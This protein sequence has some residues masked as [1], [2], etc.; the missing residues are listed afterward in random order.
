MLFVGGVPLSHLTFTL[1]PLL[2]LAYFFMM[3]AGYRVRR[4]MSFLNPWEYSSNEG[5]QIIH[6]LLAFGTGGIWGVGIGKGYQKLFYLPEPHT[7]FIF[8]IIGEELGLVGVLAILALYGMVVGRGLSISRKI[9]E[10]FGSYLA[11]GM[12]IAI[13]IQVFI[14]MGVTLGLLPTKGLVLPFLSYG[15][16]SLILNMASIGILMNIESISS[17]PVHADPRP[18]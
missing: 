6:S 18:R 15:G 8:S 16:S 17:Q 11:F 9:P 5:Y 7:D 4:I 13:A 10:L 3:D 2:P 1:I 12:T 14:N